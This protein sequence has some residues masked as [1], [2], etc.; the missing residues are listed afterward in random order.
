MPPSCPH[1]GPIMVPSPARDPAQS[2]GAIISRHAHGHK[3]HASTTH[4]HVEHV[5]RLTTRPTRLDGTRLESTR[6]EATRLDGADR[7]SSFDRLATA[8]AHTLAVRRGRGDQATTAGGVDRCLTGELPAVSS[9][10]KET[11]RLTICVEKETRASGPA[12]LRV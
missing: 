9:K 6:L 5:A 10:M 12:Q 11:A 3:T 7:R 4:A 1:H 2:G 8:R